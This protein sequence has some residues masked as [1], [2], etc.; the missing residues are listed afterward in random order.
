MRAFAARSLLVLVLIFMVMMAWAFHGRARAQGLADD[1]F[2]MAQGASAW[3]VTRS[4]RERRK[5]HPRAGKR[6]RVVP[7]PRPRPGYVAPLVVGGFIRGRLICAA[8]VNAALAARGIR[9]TGSR[10]AKSFLS[11]GRPSGP[12]PGAVAVFSRG[13]RG[14]HVAIVHSVRPNGEVI[15]LNPSS[16]R[17]AWEIG[18]YRRKPIA[19]RVAS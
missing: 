5:T 12:T 7:V 11:W 15:Y 14:G 2:Q 17:Q 10:F 16:R 6:P 8:N 1:R 13:R 9:G 3:D 4:M 18:P 19:Y